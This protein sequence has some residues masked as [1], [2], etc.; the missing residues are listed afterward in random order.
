M[1][2]RE[3]CFPLGIGNVAAVHQRLPQRVELGRQ[4]GIFR[5][6]GGSGFG[7][8]GGPGHVADEVHDRVASLDVE[9]ELVE[10]DAAVVL[11]ILLDLHLHIVAREIVAKLIAVIAKFIRH[12]GQENPH[13]HGGSPAGDIPP[14]GSIT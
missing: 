9:V 13:R 4:V 12:R 2:K 14:A 10:R 3:P 8:R 5:Q 6:N 7:L 1:I 11:E